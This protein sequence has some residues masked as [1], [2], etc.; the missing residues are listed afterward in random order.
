MSQV[1]M[2]TP[3]LA[4][5]GYLCLLAPMAANPAFVDPIQFAY[6]ARTSV[7]LL[8]LNIAFIG[9]I[10]YGLGAST[11]DTI[12][13]EDEL[14]RV[15]YQMVYSCVPAAMALGSTSFLLYA[16]PLTVP[17]VVFGF[18]NLILTQLVTMQVDIKCVEND[19]APKWFLKFRTVNFTIYM[20]I[21]SLIFL[22]YYSRI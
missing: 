12:Y 22:I 3:L 16:S 20:I 10:H 14:K 2:S 17:H 7:R 5:T 19:M 18:T 11:Y 1:M 8:A 15:K 4:V 21:T 13:E 6:L 9:G